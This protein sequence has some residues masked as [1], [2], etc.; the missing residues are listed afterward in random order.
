M[1]LQILCPEMVVQAVL[2]HERQG[3][4]PH[5]Q[6]PSHADAHSD[7]CT[8]REGDVYQEAVL[9]CGNKVKHQKSI[10]WCAVCSDIAHCDVSQGK[11][12]STHF[13]ANEGNM[14]RMRHCCI[15]SGC[16]FGPDLAWRAGTL[17]G[18]WCTQ[19]ADACG[20]TH[21]TGLCPAPA[22]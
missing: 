7:D 20:C 9:R 10:S 14:E 17:Q 19:T 21:S 8:F 18:S 15:P 5:P 2:Y 3:V 12:T 13:K 6:G 22:Q 4:T 16:S 1:H 11:L